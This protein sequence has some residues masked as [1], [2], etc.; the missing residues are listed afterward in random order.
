MGAVGL[1]VIGAVLAGALG[2]SI[3]SFAAVVIDRLPRGEALGGRSRCVCGQRI[4]AVDN[5]PVVS[6]L[7]RRGRARCCGARIP[8]W[9]VLVE[10]IGVGL[11]VAIFLLLSS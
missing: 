5:V 10:L 7:M 6:Y 11:G 1:R 4:R 3:A 9:Y 8:A 2:G